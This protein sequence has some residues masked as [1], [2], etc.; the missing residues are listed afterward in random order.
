MKFLRMPDLTESQETGG[1]PGGAAGVPGGGAGVPV[2]VEP[3]SRPC[4]NGDHSSE[5]EGSPEKEENSVLPSIP[6]A[7]LQKL[8]LSVSQQT[9]IR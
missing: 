9:E 4:Q 5:E 6:E 8:G 1:N 7:F 3:P 2:L